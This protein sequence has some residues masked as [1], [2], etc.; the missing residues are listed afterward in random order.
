MYQ[1]PAKWAGGWA[2][3][4]LT[5]HLEADSSLPRPLGH[6]SND[7]HW[8]DQP[9]QI[10][11]HLSHI[12]TARYVGGRC[13]VRPPFTSSAPPSH[14]WTDGQTGVGGNR[15]TGTD[16]SCSWLIP[17]VCK[18]TASWIHIGSLV[19]E[20][21]QCIS[22]HALCRYGQYLTNIFDRTIPS[23]G[24]GLWFFWQHLLFHLTCLNLQIVK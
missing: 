4:V 12:S 11:Y 2:L 21:L 18:C 3:K 22:E 17:N 9:G 6:L 16:S 23:R 7:Q 5:E 13:E 19:F 24:T 20:K 10:A 1:N 14:R 15:L 8:A